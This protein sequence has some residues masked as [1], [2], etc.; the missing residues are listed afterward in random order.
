MPRL[1]ISITESNQE[2]GSFREDRSTKVLM[3]DQLGRLFIFFCEAVS[4]NMN[5]VVLICFLDVCHSTITSYQ[6]VLC[7]QCVSVDRLLH[8]AIVCFRL[9]TARISSAREITLK[10]LAFQILPQVW[11]FEKV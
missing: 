8:L 4:H 7:V 10:S 5:S 3:M 1:S 2:N 9:S 11:C 6:R